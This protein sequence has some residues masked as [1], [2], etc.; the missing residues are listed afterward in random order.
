MRMRRLT[1]FC[2]LVWIG[3]LGVTCES[4]FA[5]PVSSFSIYMILT[6]HSALCLRRSTRHSSS[7]KGGT[8]N[9]MPFHDN[10][11]DLFI[12]Y[13]YR[14]KKRDWIATRAFGIWLMKNS[15]N[16]SIVINIGHDTFMNWNQERQLLGIV[17]LTLPPSTLSR[18]FSLLWAEVVT[19]S[20]TSS[21]HSGKAVWRDAVGNNQVS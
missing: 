17:R 18:E 13:R 20:L 6:S 9:T 11:S 12:S 16:L 10:K 8:F 19:L 5:F 14:S 7:S 3:K 1:D 2:T 21:F 4:P 15:L